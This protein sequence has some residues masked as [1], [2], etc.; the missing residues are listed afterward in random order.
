M[1]CASQPEMS[2]PVAQHSTS[3]RRTVTYLIVCSSSSNFLERTVC[4]VHLKCVQFACVVFQLVTRIRYIQRIGGEPLICLA[5]TE[6]CISKRPGHNFRKSTSILERLR[7]FQSNER[8][9]LSKEAHGQNHIVI[10]I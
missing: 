1:V 4:F 9:F 6:Y 7:T 8:I 5:D 10:V 2:F 3:C